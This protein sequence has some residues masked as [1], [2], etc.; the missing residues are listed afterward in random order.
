MAYDLGGILIVK[1]EEHQISEKFK[2]R[3]FVVETSKEVGDNTYTENIK[4]QLTQEKCDLLEDYKVGEGIKVMFNI[5]G[6]RWEKNGNVS[7]FVNL[8]AWGLNKETA[9][10]T[11]PD[12]TSHMP[13][14]PVENDPSDDVPF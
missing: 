5:K 11:N 9:Q 10:V 3:E 2:K 8:D 7:Y 6:N 12:T 4:F 1:G 13:V 14:E